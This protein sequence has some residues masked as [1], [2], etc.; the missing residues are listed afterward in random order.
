MIIAAVI[1]GITYLAIAMSRIPSAIIAILGATAMVTALAILSDFTPHEALQYVDLEV[2]F[3]L[4]GMM[5]LADVMSRT[6]AFEWAARQ[7]ARLVKGNGFFLIILLSLI[8]AVGSALLDNVTTVVIMVPITLS[9][10]KSLDLNPI[11]FLL[12]EVYASNIGGTATIVGDP[13]NIIVA[14]QANISFSEFF[15][16]MAPVSALS[17]CA[18]FILLYL[19]FKN[20]V[21]VNPLKREQLM[22]EHPTNL[23]KDSNLLKKSL[24]VFTLTIIGFFFADQIGISPAFV[25]IGGAALVLLFSG[26]NPGEVLKEVEWTTL[27]FFAGLF[28]LVGGLEHVGIIDRISEWIVSLA[29][30]SDGTIT[31]ESERNL[32]IIM[33]W[34]SGGLSAFI[35][36]IPFAT[37]MTP[38]VSDL[39]STNEAMNSGNSTNP[40]WWALTLG[41]DLGGNFTIVGAS[42]NVV[43][44][45]MARAS[46]Y[47]IS[48]FQFFKYGA[49]ISVVSLAISCG[50]ILLRYY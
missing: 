13:P 43:V 34:L 48:F 47:P 10:C 4:A 50:Y 1:F 33:V 14:S 22:S 31:R 30:N 44:F 2:I 41:A 18:L 20:S 15:I 35:D 37:T 45:T 40:L 5:V 42:A 49:V 28:M 36:N 12:A 16:N 25:A 8:T 21:T 3:L 46:G 39:L 17:L 23:I 9:L 19:W 24:F 11:P 38:V 6:G 7:G 26:L 27:C 29:S 32:S